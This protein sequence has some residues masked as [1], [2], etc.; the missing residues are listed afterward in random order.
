MKNFYADMAL[1]IALAR[2]DDTAAG[3]AGAKDAGKKGGMSTENIAI[4]V[5]MVILLLAVGGFYLSCW[6][7]KKR[8]QRGED[9]DSDG[10]RQS[11]YE[12]K[13][14]VEKLRKK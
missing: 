10:E 6:L 9:Q 1:L 13:G 4:M 14:I 7:K 3:D 12:Y 5:V 8:N 2:A 11:S